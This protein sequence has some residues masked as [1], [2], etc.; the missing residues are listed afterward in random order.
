[1][2]LALPAYRDRIPVIIDEVTTLWGPG[3]LID[4]IVTERGIACARL[5]GEGEDRGPCRR[6]DQVGRRDATRPTTPKGACDHRP[7]SRAHAGPNSLTW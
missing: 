4:V 3:E 2:F 6:G 5:A 1:M 7:M